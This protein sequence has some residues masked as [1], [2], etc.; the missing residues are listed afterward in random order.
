MDKPTTIAL[1]D[2]MNDCSFAI[3]IYDASQIELAKELMRAGLSAWYEAAHENIEDDEYFTAEEK[4]AMYNDGYAEP[5]LELLERYGIE[6]K[7]IELE[8][9]DDGIPLVDETFA[10]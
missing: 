7:L 8:Y 6:H 2:Q 1:I 3:E 5:A 9:D 10:Y 4:S